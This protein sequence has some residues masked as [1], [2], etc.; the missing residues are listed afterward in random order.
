MAL[1]IKNYKKIKTDLFE[2][3]VNEFDFNKSHY[4]DDKILR[5]KMNAV[6]KFLQKLV[7]KNGYRE[8][9][10]DTSIDEKTARVSEG[11]PS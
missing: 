6:Y 7:T 1:K 8:E 9:T 4:A 5:I 2:V 11:Y 10:S 3:F